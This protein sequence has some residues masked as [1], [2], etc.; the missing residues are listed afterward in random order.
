MYESW[1]SSKEVLP[2]LMEGSN[3]RS[4]KIIATDGR[5]IWFT[6]YHVRGE[7]WCSD[8]PPWTRKITHWQYV[9]LP[10]IKEIPE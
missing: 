3:W 5:D 2:G 8:A 1:I 6:H 9:V 10:K 7:R 4:S